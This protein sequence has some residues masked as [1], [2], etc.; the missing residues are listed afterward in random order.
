MTQILGIIPHSALPPD[1]D[2]IGRFV[3]SPDPP[4][5]EMFSD[6]KILKMC[7]SYLYYTALSVFYM[8]FLRNFQRRKSECFPNFGIQ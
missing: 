8:P 7:N 6:G 2:S 5:I 1:A 3:L 4:N